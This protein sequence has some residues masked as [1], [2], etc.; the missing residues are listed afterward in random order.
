MICLKCNAF[1]SGFVGR[2]CPVCSEPLLLE[3]AANRDKLVIGRLQEYLAL[4]YKSGKVSKKAVNE[5]ENAISETNLFAEEKE[6]NSHFGFISLFLDWL[7]GLATGFFISLGAL[8]EPMIRKPN[9]NKYRKNLSVK[10]SEASYE[11]LTEG[12]LSGDNSGASSLSGLDAVSELDS[13]HHRKK[14]KYKHDKFKTNT[15]EPIFEIWA[16]MRPLF[17]E[18]IWWFIGTLLVLT[19]SIMGIREAWLVLT[20]ISRHITVLSAVFLYQILFMALGI[21]LGSRSATTGRLLSGISLLLLPVSFSVVSDVILTN[22]IIGFVT[23]AVLVGLSYFILRVISSKQFQMEANQFILPILPSMV[24]LTLIPYFGI[25][26]PSIVLSFLPLAAIYKISKNITEEKIGSKGLFLFSIYGAL[27]VIAV[28]LNLPLENNSRF[29]LGSLSIGVLFLWILGLSAIL[30]ITFGMYGFR[31]ESRRVY[32]I[33]EILFL[34]VTLVLAS[35]SGIF[36]FSTQTWEINENLVRLLYV[37]I[38]I[39]VSILFYDTISRHEMAIHPFMVLSIVSSYLLVKEIAPPTIWSIAFAPIVPITKMLYSKDESPKMRRTLYGWGVISGIVSCTILI[40]LSPMFR[41]NNIAVIDIL[42]EPLTLIHT[43]PILFAGIYFAIISHRVA[44]LTRSILHLSA[45]F[46]TFTFVYG[47]FLFYFPMIDSI[48]KIGA[49]L[50]L[51]SVFYHFAAIKFE[52][53]L[54]KNTNEEN[55][56]LFQPMDDISLLAGTLSALTL[57]FVFNPTSIMENS[58]VALTG[59][60]LITRSFRDNSSFSSFLG[61]ILV[62][63]VIFRISITYFTVPSTAVSAFVSSAVA[64]WSGILCVLFPNLTPADIKSRKVFFVIRLPFAAQGQ[65]LVR[66]AL[67]ATSLIYVLYSIGLIFVWLG[68]PDQPERNWVILSGFLLTLT[69]SVAFFTRAFNSFYLRG[70]TVCLALIFFSVGLVAVANRIG[71]PLPP[72]VVGVNLT[73]VIIGIWLFSRLLFHKG[74]ALANW[75]DNPSQGKFYHHIPLSVM[76]LLGFILIL[77]VFLLQPYSIPRFLY[78]TPPTFFVGA[79]LAAFFYSRALQSLIPL[80]LTLSLFVL[81]SILGF[82]Q[83]SFTGTKLVALDLPGSR[84]VPQITE[85]ATRVGDWLDPIIFLPPNLNPSSLIIRSATG[86]AAIGTFYTFCVLLLPLAAL[87][88]GIRKI[89]F[90]MEDF[91]T[92]QHL[93]SSWSVICTAL[94]TL[95]AF[96]YAFITPA[97]LSLIAGGLLVLAR[98]SKMGNV[99]VGLSG[100]LILHGFA[101][102][103]ST[104][105]IWGGIVFAGVGL[106]MVLAVKPISFFSAKAYSRI[107]ES[108][109]VGAFLYSSIGFIYALATLSTSVWDNAVPGLLVGVWIGI[110]GFWMETLALGITSGIIA[111]SLFVGALQWTKTL[112]TIAASLSMF[113]IAFAGITAF[114]ILCRQGICNVANGIQL[115]PEMIPYFAL[116]VSVVSGVSYFIS[117][118]IKQKREDFSLG[119]AFSSDTLIVLTGLLLS[120]FMS[121]SIPSRLKWSNFAVLL[122]IGIVIFISLIASFRERKGRHLYFTQTSIASLYLALKQA[123]PETLTPQVDAIA[124]LVFGFILTGVTSVAHRLGI[125]PLEQSTR[126]FAALMPVVAVIV[127]PTEFSYENAGMATFSTVIYAALAITSSHRIYAVLAAVAANLAILTAIMASQVQGIEIYLA[128]LGLFFLFLGHIFRENLTDQA[129][130]IIRVSGGLLLY[131]PASVNISFEMGRAADPMYALI[132][133]L[134]SLAGVV[135]GMIFQI[136]SYFFMGVSFFTLNLIAN[137]LQTGLR[138]QRMGFILL[139]LTGIFIIGSL[140]TYTLKK[141]TILGFVEHTQKKLAKWE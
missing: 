136:R 115:L 83:E 96:Q 61:S 80:Q 110:S 78:I 22:T 121:L 6:N 3:T 91:L 31:V 130:K 73:F 32:V 92:L 74:Q 67:S 128:P 133:G 17:N 77:D 76:V 88:S 30:T 21:F 33:L 131:L 60:I 116:I 111:L 15:E 42:K 27:A 93:F 108:S 13:K 122:S 14:A 8:F 5:I 54:F 18:Y 53:V 64:F 99:S 103:N 89:I 134:L 94:L 66:N 51:V 28:Y 132:F 123:F 114:P 104:Y 119:A 118:N 36:I 75:L 120:I 135:C 138:D 101:H 43:G 40:Y 50:G 127:L 90:H 25:G 105:P 106:L 139:S 7:Q 86:I 58:F 68:L 69:F 102:Q 47:I 2:L 35:I 52:K 26:I 46:G 49:S 85:A 29:Q 113:F 109:H 20:G 124:A 45:A 117:E 12:I 1:H 107:L 44:G 34:A 141:E 72:T 137:L 84:W 16:G 62:S 24:V 4:W 95:I 56:S 112:T 41:F 65:V 125:P 39:L 37:T 129:I 23:L 98:F 87:S 63:L 19:G 97:F 10:D 9:S 71:R 59:L 79:G 11:S 126:R 81:A 55:D 57:L 82:V 100:I 140:V 48:S 38:P 70:S